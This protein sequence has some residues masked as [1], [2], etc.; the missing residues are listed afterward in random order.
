MSLVRQYEASLHNF[1][2]SDV[3]LKWNWLTECF[4]IARYEFIDL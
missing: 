3:D 2:P 1:N 4:E